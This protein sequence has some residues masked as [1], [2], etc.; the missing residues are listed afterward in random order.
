MREMWS[1]RT[2]ERGL[3]WLKVVR[4]PPFDQGAMQQV[5]ERRRD[6]RTRV[7]LPTYIVRRGV[8]EAVELLDASY[9]GL[10]IRMDEPPPE[11][12][13]VKLIVELPGGRALDCHAVVV[14]LVGDALGRTGVGLRFFALN[15]QDRSEWEGFIAGILHR[16]ERAA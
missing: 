1:R 12:Q 4:K 13:L 2:R 6:A 7:S 8:T 16:R 11:R 10:F 9:R 3:S 5:D 14:R 15:G